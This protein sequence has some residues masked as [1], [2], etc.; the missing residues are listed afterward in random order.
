MLLMSFLLCASLALGGCATASNAT[1]SSVSKTIAETCAAAG[2]AVQVLAL[3]QQQGKLNT[4]TT[5]AVDS[6]I[7]VTE[8]ICIAPTPPSLSSAEMTAFT[9]AATQLTNYSLQYG[10]RK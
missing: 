7:A 6:F 4:T 5:N 2:A 8:P 1:Q 3:A 9:G 10:E